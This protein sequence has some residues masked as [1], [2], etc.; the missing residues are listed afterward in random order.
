MLRIILVA[1]CL[2]AAACVA[3]NDTVSDDLDTQKD[4]SPADVED[5][6]FLNTLE[7]IHDT[8]PTDLL[9]LSPIT[10]ETCSGIEGDHPCNLVGPDQRGDIFGLYANYGRPMVVDFS[11]GWCGPCRNAAVHAE[12]V[13][14]LYQDSGLLYVTVLIETA[15]GS[16]PTQQDVAAWADEYGNVDSLVVGGS[17]AMLQSGGGTWPLSGWPTFYYI[18]DEMVLRDIDRGYNAQEVIH[19]I[20]WLLSL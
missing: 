6:V 10:W 3:P 8:D 20:D 12:E 19:S 2:L 15:N 14:N 5:D 13:Q 7:G 11:A 9:P 17:R 18:D 1:F 4:L 16:V